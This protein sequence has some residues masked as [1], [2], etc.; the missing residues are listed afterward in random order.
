MK[1]IGLKELNNAES[2]VSVVASAKQY[3]H[4]CSTFNCINNP[5]K[6]NLLLYLDG[7]DA[8]YTDKNGNKSNAKSGDIIYTPLG[9]EYSVDFINFKSKDSN[10]VGINFFIYDR[11]NNPF[12][13]TDKIKIFTLHD[14]SMKI[15]FN[16]VES[17]F[18]RTL[19]D[20]AKMKAGMYDIISALCEKSHRKHFNKYSIISKGILYMEQENDQNLSVSEIASLCGV[21]EIYFRR[22]F[23]EYS[24]M[25]PVDYRIHHKIERAKILLEYENMS[26]TEIA[27]MLSFS[28]TPYFIKTFK[29]ITG[30]TPLQYRNSRK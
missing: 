16:K 29:R 13:F 11:E 22:L 20:Y 12:I 5:K 25:S 18:T 19:T 4:R 1:I 26:V 24:G 14:S 27:E 7:C 9:C 17:A 21:S 3:W 15:L 2:H 8:V 30:I 28:G 23:K 6:V 10:T